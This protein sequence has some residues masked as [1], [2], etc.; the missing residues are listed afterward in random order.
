MSAAVSPA[1]LAVRAA[2][3]AAMAHHDAGRLREAEAGYRE[4]L[5]SAPG[6]PD[7]LALLATLEQATGRLDEALAH[8]DEALRTSGDAAGLHNVRGLVLEARGRLGEA[9]AAYRKA[10][11]LAPRFAPALFNLGN[12]L[13]ARARG[14][15]AIAC[16][17]RALASEPR[18][19]AAWNNLGVA[20]Q[21]EGHLEEALAAYRSALEQADIPESRTNFARCAAMAP[22]IPADAGFRALV[23]RALAE[24]WIRPADLARTAAT[25][26]SADEALA[27]DELLVALL[28][29]AQVCDAALERRLGEARRALLE[30]MDDA[31][32]DDRLALACALACQGFLNDYAFAVG[33]DEARRLRALR[34]RI[35]TALASGEAVAPLPLA[36]LAAYVS[37]GTLAGADALAA[38]PWPDAFARVVARQLVE[39]REEREIR[40]RIPSLTPVRS[41]VS[42]AVRRQY[43]ESPYPRWVACARVAPSS[44]E[45]HLREMLPGAA[46]GAIARDAPRE[47]LVAGCGTGQES[48]EIARRF[49]QARLLAIDLS[50]ASLGFARRQSEALGVAN[51][52][53][54]QADIAELGELGGRRFDLVSS[55]G[56]LHHLGDPVAGWRRLAALLA[57]G[58]LMQVGLYSE[59]ARRG[60]VRARDFIARRGFEPTPEG[61]RAARA[62]LRAEPEFAAVTSLRDFFGTNEC[63]DLLF[64]VEEHRFTLEAIAGIV[65]ALGLEWI[66]LAVDPATRRRHAA[67]FP[68]AAA[69]HDPASWAAFEREFPDTFAGMYL[70]WVRRPAETG[71]PAPLQ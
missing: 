68:D 60:I 28:L 47:I 38:R 14:E 71:P 61:I 12:L 43:E 69:R 57:P 6:R 45:P 25:L 24:A 17:R 18:Y 32:G 2:L 53:Y 46:I 7:A 36:I 30:S 35:E 67:R 44:L 33:E 40:D 54:A 8:V 31:A 13:R 63:R 56:V 37:L 15:E 19:A 59:A 52:E 4:V 26:L 58:G 65:A 1:E 3:R 10:C 5:A 39:P 9:E 51:V 11:A 62:A 49:P 27:P 20:L 50:L 22:R 34:E 64:H 66:G 23:A 55:V 29:H 41:E 42:R 70:F 48:T 16:Y 21:D